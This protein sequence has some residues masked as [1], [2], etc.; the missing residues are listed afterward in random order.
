MQIVSQDRKHK[1]YKIEEPRSVYA[2]LR[3]WTGNNIVD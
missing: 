1:Q 2:K 3:P